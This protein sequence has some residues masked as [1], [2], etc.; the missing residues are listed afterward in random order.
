MLVIT[1][2]IQ[3]LMPQYDFVL[4]TCVCLTSSKFLPIQD[5]ICLVGQ[6]IASYTLIENVMLLCVFNK[7]VASI[8]DHLF[9]STDQ[10]LQDV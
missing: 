7:I 2:C 9:F 6:M 10:S 4:A 8:C 3:S 1:Y 5:N